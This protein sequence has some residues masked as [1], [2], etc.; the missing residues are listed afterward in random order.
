M[1][2]RAPPLLL[3][4]PAGGLR[5]DYGFVCHYGPGAPVTPIQVGYAH[6]EFESLLDETP[7]E[8]YTGWMMSRAETLWR[9]AICCYRDNSM[10]NGGITEFTIGRF[11]EA[12]SDVKLLEN[13]PQR[14]GGMREL[15]S[16]RA[17]HRH[18]NFSDLTAYRHYRGYVPLQTGPPHLAG[19][20]TDLQDMVMTL[21]GQVTTL[22]GQQ[23]PLRSS[24]KLP[25][26][27]VAVS[28]D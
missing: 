24:H 23:D 15:R 18:S 22:Q 25:E 11:V 1:T 28:L 26:E 14:R 12:E 10:H 4:R 21:Q 13:R 9:R 7:D 8:I 27:L 19:A 17:Q 6:E 20:G 3:P 16:C 5:A 2:A